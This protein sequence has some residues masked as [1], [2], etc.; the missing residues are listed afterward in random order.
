MHYKNGRLAKEGDKIVT[1]YGM[2]ILHSTN[3]S[4]ET[5]NGRIAVTTASDAYV[6][7]SECLHFDDVMK[8]VVPDSSAT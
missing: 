7:L 1:P 8:A 5:C 6:T 4:S 2:G 3:A